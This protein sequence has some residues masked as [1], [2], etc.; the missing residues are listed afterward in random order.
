MWR[1]VKKKM[2]KIDVMH[3]VERTLK[4]AWKEELGNSILYI[5]T[6]LKIFQESVLVFYI[7]SFYTHFF[8]I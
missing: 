1:S 2:F 7:L 8:K 6:S 3:H 4:E 5:T